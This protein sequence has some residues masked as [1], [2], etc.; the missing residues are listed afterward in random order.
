MFL[1]ESHPSYSYPADQLI[2]YYYRLYRRIFASDHPR[3]KAEQLERAYETIGAVVEEFAIT[4]FDEEQVYS[5]VHQYFQTQFPNCDYRLNHF[6]S[7]EIIRNRIYEVA[8]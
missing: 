4:D 7:E 8:H 5:I 6:A 3:L 1:D 2:E